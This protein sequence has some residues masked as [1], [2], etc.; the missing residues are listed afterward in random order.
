MAPPSAL[1]CRVL[2]LALS[3]CDGDGIG[4]LFS[5]AKLIPA[6]PRRPWSTFVLK[7]SRETSC[8]A[9][10]STCTSAPRTCF[11]DGGNQV[12]AWRTRTRSVASRAQAC[13]GR[14]L[15]FRETHDS[16]S[17]SINLMPW[18]ADKGDMVSTSWPTL[19]NSPR[20]NKR[21]GSQKRQSIV[22]GINCPCRS[23]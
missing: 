3:R 14:R 11:R 16:G 7:L 6:W 12:S 20:Q 13:D 2:M 22:G 21:S 17:T 9:H 15:R 23:P 8:E 1:R 10:G 5:A 4:S 18:Q 19:L